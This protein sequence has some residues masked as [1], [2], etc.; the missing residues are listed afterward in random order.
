MEMDS[1]EEEIKAMEDDKKSRKKLTD[2]KEKV[3]EVL[4]C[5]GSDFNRLKA[6]ELIDLLRWYQVPPNEL[7]GKDANYNKWLEICGVDP[8]PYLKWT[9]VDE[10]RLVELKKGRLISP[11][12]HWGAINKQTGGNSRLPF[13]STLTSSYHL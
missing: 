7:G 13:T 11:I 12:L 4:A 5:V 6:T 9:D 10:A 1:R 8:P 3:T 2:V